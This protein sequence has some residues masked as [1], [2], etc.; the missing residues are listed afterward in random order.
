V[1]GL[2]AEAGDEA[3]HRR[4]GTAV[5][6]TTTAVAGWDEARQA[7]ERRWQSAWIAHLVAV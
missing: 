3:E 6:T 5:Q 7:A 2:V 1:V 4:P